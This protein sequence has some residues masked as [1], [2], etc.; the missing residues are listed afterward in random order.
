MAFAFGGDVVGF[1]EPSQTHPE[2]ER[3]AGGQWRAGWSRRAA[4]RCE[5]RRGPGCRL[6]GRG[7]CGPAA[8]ETAGW[9]RGPARRIS[10]CVPGPHPG[11]SPDPGRRLTRSTRAAAPRAARPAGARLTLKGEVS[12]DQYCLACSLCRGPISAGPV[13][14]P[15]A[16]GLCGLLSECS[17]VGGA[18]QGFELSEHGP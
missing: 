13:G 18:V 8:T 4:K 3:S 10:G 9:G 6:A 12:H 17:A 7:G 11:P 14:E 16:S 15:G 2:T 5:A 1:D